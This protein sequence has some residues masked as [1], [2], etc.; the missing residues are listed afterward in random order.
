[1]ELY[2]ATHVSLVFDKLP[3]SPGWGKCY[4][5]AP[6]PWLPGLRTLCSSRADSGLR[7]LCTPDPG[8]PMLTFAPSP[9]GPEN[10]ASIRQRYG[11]GYPG[12][13]F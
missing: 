5:K 11:D 6:C 7:P 1:M 3:P 13:T 8:D 12:D 10:G 4:N 2:P 9:Q